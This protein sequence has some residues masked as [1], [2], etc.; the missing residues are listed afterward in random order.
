MCVPTDRA[1]QAA[2][3]PSEPRRAA[4]IGG[5]HCTA[6]A[7][8]RLSVFATCPLS[9]SLSHTRFRGL[10]VSTLHEL[11]LWPRESTFKSRSAIERGRLKFASLQVRVH[12]AKTLLISASLGVPAVALGEWLDAELVEAAAAAAAEAPPP[13][14]PPPTGLPAYSAAAAISADVDVFEVA[15]AA[16]AAAAAAA[17][18]AEEVD[19]AA[20]RLAAPLTGGNAGAVA[21]VTAG[22]EEGSILISEVGMS[23]GGGGD[24][25][26]RDSGL[27]CLSRTFQWKGSLGER[28]MLRRPHDRRRH[29]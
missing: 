22:A 7:S 29:C 14:P 1:C 9:L 20:F 18:A 6:C 19:E 2:R 4:R 17:A 3:A 25:C 11:N 10:G 12:V 21:T 8:V 28:S 24:D 27:C 15:A 5:E 26:S 16:T 13:L 23:C